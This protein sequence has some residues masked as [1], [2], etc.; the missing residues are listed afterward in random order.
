[1][2]N[3]SKQNKIAEE[4]LQKIK[5]GRIS[6]RPKAYFVAKAVAVIFLSIFIF[7]ISAFILSYIVFSLKA[8]GKLFLLGFGWRGFVNF[9]ILF[10][11]FFLLVD[12]I[13]VFALDWFLKKFSFGYHAP[14]VYL[15]LGSTAAAAAIGLVF[16][17]TPLHSGFLRNAETGKI[18]PPAAELYDGLRRPPRGL[19]IFRG[20]VVSIATSSFEMLH[21][22]LDGDEDTGLVKVQFPPDINPA[23]F[24]EEGEHVFVA[25]DAA[26]G[27]IRAYGVSRFPESGQ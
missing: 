27:T 14:L 21:D 9:A 1:M 12:V 7:L 18:P 22:D 19:G 16:T 5:S 11:W 6:M 23:D 24:V 20:T 25:G 15:F 3:E 26:S 2:E 4:V 17:A 8:S 10:P 13:L